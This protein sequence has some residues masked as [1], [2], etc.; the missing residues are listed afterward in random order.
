MSG[1]VA[2]HPSADPARLSLNTA[3]T[4]KQWG[5]AQA[6]EGCARHGL[7]G[8]APWRDQLHAM[9]VQAA[10]RSI[11]AH[12]LTVTGL[13]RGGMFPAAD[14][15]GRKAAIDD[16]LHAIDEAHAL[17]AQCL[18][19]VVGGL[20]AGSKDIGGARSQVR[21]GIAAILPHARQAGIPLAIEPLH[22]MYAADRACINSLA[23]ALD[24]CDA[25][26]P[27]REGGLGVAV[28]VYHVWWDPQLESQIARAGRDRLLAFHICDWL[29][30]TRDLL[31]D[32]GMMGDG[33]IDLPR[34]RAWV[35]S[36]GYAGFHEVEIFSERDWWQRDPGRSARNLQGAPP[37]LLLKLGGARS[38]K[39]AKSHARSRK[40]TMKK[41]RIALVGLGMAVAPHA[42]SALDLTDR[43]EVVYAFSPSAE[44][45]AAFAAKFPFPQCDRL[46]TIFEDATV[47]AVAVLTPPNT[48]LELVQRCAAAGKHVLLEKPLEITTARA[49]KM[50]A[51]C[52]AAGVKLGVVLQ[53]RHRPATERLAGAVRSG[54]LGALLGASAHVQMWRP[55][56]YYDEPGRGTR[57]RDGGGV[58]LTQ[59]I[60]TLDVLLSLAGEPAEVKAFA[61]TTPVH[62]MEC[63]DYACA[64]VRWKNGALGVIEATTAAYPGAPERI[65]LAGTRG[66]A[67][68]AGTALELRWQDGR[69]ETLAAD[70]SSGG[71]GA[72]PMAFPHDYHR[73]VWRTFLDAV[74]GGGEP[75]VTGE[76]A[77]R[78]HRLIDALLA[79]AGD[80]KREG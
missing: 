34:I 69:R 14:A 21:E 63:E 51:A 53:Y 44:R 11:R 79:S 33:V 3:T 56:S 23:Q 20:P 74:Q 55:Q 4:R 12:E 7:R 22:P 64:A 52:R 73:A 8:I 72:D 68:L 28:D 24:L 50:V 46:E 17:D 70:G 43:A 49:E 48:H 39:R 10:A 71:S 61:A 76:E 67:T 58:L 75:R 35:E 37:P 29:V 5:L 77:L 36:A 30:P 18:V 31:N 2:M 42:R 9:G 57:A 78:V 25:L 27:Q 16:N 62:R 38:S 13:C 1:D 32:R 26:D 19:L 45:R 47:D 40:D 15:A 41:T 60:H 59:A 65:E 66:T 54:E 6:I 80:V